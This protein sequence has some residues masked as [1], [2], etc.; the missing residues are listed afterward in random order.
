MIL[1]RSDYYV[2]SLGILFTQ[3]H[4]IGLRGDIVWPYHLYIFDNLTGDDLF[5]LDDYIFDEDGDLV[6]SYI[7]PNTGR[8]L[9]IHTA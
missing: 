8:L 1:Q 7:A 9:R 2:G 3:A 5:I 6:M 4:Q